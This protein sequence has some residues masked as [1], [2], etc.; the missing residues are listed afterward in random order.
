MSLGTRERGIKK[1]RKKHQRQKKKEN[2]K[3]RM[4]ETGIEGR[5]KDRGKEELRREGKEC[6]NTDRETQRQEWKGRQMPVKFLPNEHLPPGP[7]FSGGG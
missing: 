3:N 4:G 1:K 2:K 5:E 7:R 6:P